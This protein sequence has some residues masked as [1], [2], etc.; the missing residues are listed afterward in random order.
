MKKIR[1]FRL[2]LECVLLASG[3]VRLALV[4]LNMA[5]NYRR[6]AMPRNACS[7]DFAL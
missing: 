4:L 1:K 2:V 3:L 5:H 6:G 7:V